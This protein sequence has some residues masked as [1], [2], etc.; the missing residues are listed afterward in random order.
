MVNL[1]QFAKSVLKESLKQ[2]LLIFFF[3]SFWVFWSGIE[4]FCLYECLLHC[5]T[6]DGGAIETYGWKTALTGVAEVYSSPRI[7][8][9][10]AANS[11]DNVFAEF[12]LHRML[13][14]NC[15]QRSR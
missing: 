3:T 1:P 5:S 15:K 12:L 9:F 11:A 4:P 7:R 13:M 8:F 10:L 2:V 6:S 14:F